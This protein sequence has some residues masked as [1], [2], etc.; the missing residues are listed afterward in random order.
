MHSGTAKVTTLASADLEAENSF[1]HPTAVA[2]ESST[3]EVKSGKISVQLR[4][5]SVTVFRFPRSSGACR[6][7]RSS[8]SALGK[9]RPCRLLVVL[10]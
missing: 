4:P 3:A 2:P 6:C 8:K 1:D 9:A 7:E 10:R 5:Y